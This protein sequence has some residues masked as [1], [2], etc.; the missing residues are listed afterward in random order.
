MSTILDTVSGVHDLLTAHSLPQT[1]EIVAR[2]GGRSHHFFFGGGGGGGLLAVPI[3]ILAVAGG[4][5][6]RNPDKAR[7]LKQRFSAGTGR[8]PSGYGSWSGA[9]QPGTPTSPNPP[10]WSSAP[11]A[12]GAAPHAPTQYQPPAHDPAGTTGWTSRATTPTNAV[13]VTQPGVRA[14]GW[15]PP[16]RRT[17]VQP[18]TG[19]ARPPVRL[20][21]PAGLGAG[22]VVAARAG[23]LAVLGPRPAGGAA[24]EPAFRGGYDLRRQLTVGSVSRRELRFALLMAG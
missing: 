10:G 14:G 19:V 5:F 8:S 4:Y 17:P 20:D 3:A 13:G 1:V 23:R 16:R 2:R 6:M 9:P 15:W 24:P 22:S 12:A 11:P 7:A 21:T 18:A